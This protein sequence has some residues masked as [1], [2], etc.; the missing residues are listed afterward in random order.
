MTI[1]VLYDYGKLDFMRM[2]VLQNVDCM[3]EL[4]GIVVTTKHC[5]TISKRR[6]KDRV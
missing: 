1:D 2:Q 6:V 5:S 4:I 3:A